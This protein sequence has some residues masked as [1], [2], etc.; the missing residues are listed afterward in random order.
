MIFRCECRP[1]SGDAASWAAL[2]FG[3]GGPRYERLWRLRGPVLAR[4][5][6]AEALC[7]ELLADV[8]P[9]ESLPL[10]ED[11]NGRPFL[12][13]CPLSVSLSHSGDYVAAAVAEVPIGIDLQ[14]IRDISDRVMERLYSRE[15]R[16]W[17]RAGDR[18]CRA[19]RLWTMKEAFGKHRGTGLIAGSAFF[20]AFSE[21]RPQTRY[22][23][24][25]FLFPDAP[26]GLL[27]SVCLEIP[28]E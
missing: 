24:I 8:R 19:T 12:P 17:V 23:G 4:S 20:A 25:R 22:G 27:L 15:E 10:S 9:G 14:E 1:V 6:S 21:D 3:R 5:M 11:E 18:A 26:E 7:R 13:G 28:A 16:A 2:P